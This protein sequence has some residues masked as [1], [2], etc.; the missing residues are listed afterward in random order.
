MKLRTHNKDNYTNTKIQDKITLPVKIGEWGA[1]M[2]LCL[3]LLAGLTSGAQAQKRVSNVGSDLNNINTSLECATAFTTGSNSSGYP[4]SSVDIRLK[5]VS[6][7]TTVVRIREGADTDPGDIVVTLTNPA[8]FKANALNKFTAPSGTVLNPNTTYFLVVNDGRASSAS[9]NVQLAYTYS[10]SQTGETDWSIGNSSRFRGSGSWFTTSL[11]EIPIFCINPPTVNLSVSG[12]GAI[13]EGGTPLTLT[14]TR[15]ETNTSGSNLS[16]PIQIKTTGTTAQAVD[17]MVASSISIPNNSATGTTLFGVTDDSDV[18]PTETVVIELGTL[19]SGS[20]AGSN[21]EVTLTIN[22][23]DAEPPAQPTGLMAMAG[24]VE[25]FLTWTNPESRDITN[26]QYRQKTGSNAYGNWITI[27]GS[28]AVTTTYIVTGLTN[29]TVY[30]FQVRAQVGAVG[31]AASEEVSATP[32][33]YAQTML[34][35]N[36]NTETGSLTSYNEYGTPFTTGSNGSG[37]TISSVDIFL[38]NVSGRST[39]VAIRENKN[40]NPSKLVAKLIKPNSF[41]ANTLNTFTA[42]D[43]T[44]LKPNTTYYLMVNDG[45]RRTRGVN[46]SNVQIS[47]TR[48]GSRTSVAGWSIA[49]FSR[50]RFGSAWNQALNE[51]M[52]FAIN[53]TINRPTVYLSVSGGGAINEGENPLTL[54]ATRSETNTSGLDLVIPIQVKSDGTT[55]Q[56]TDYT[57]AASISIPN[58]SAVG[59]TPFAVIDD[60]LV[61]GTETVVIELGTLPEGTIAGS[62]N[63]VTLTIND[64]PEISI[65]SR[66][67]VAVTEGTD[68]VFTVT[69]TPAPT[70]SLIVNLT[71]AEAAGSNFVTSG[72]KGSNKTVT[73]P[74]SG[75]VTYAVATVD[76]GI[77]EPNGSVM[78]TITDGSDYTVG[79]TS[80]ARVTIND[81]DTVPVINPVATASVAEGTNEVLT[82]TATDDDAGTTLMYA[83]SGGT[84]GALFSIDASSGVLTFITA[85]DFEMPSDQGRDNDYEVEVGVSDGTNST[86]QTIT[87]TVTDVNDNDPIITSDA[88]ASIVEGTTDVLTVTATDADAGAVIRYSVSG[89]ADG[90]L[91]AIE[92]TSGALTFINAPDFEG[93]SADGDDD[94]EVIVTASDG[95]N[96][97]MQTITVTVTDVNDNDPVITSDATATLAENT[98]DVLTVTATDADAGAVI[99]YSISGGADRSLFSIDANSGV[100]TFITAP[101]FEGASAD[102]DDDYEVIVT[103]SDGDNSVM[104][105]ITVTVTDVND[106]DPIITSDATASIVEGTT[107]VLT[108]TATDADEG[109][110]FTYSTSGG[111]DRNVFSINSTSGALVFRR[112][113]DFENRRDQD[114]DNDYEVE[115]GVSDGRNSV[116]Q[117]I[118]VTVT[119]DP[120]DDVLGF[121]ADEEEAVIFPNPSGDYLEVRSIAEGTFQL[122][123]LSG[124]RLL[125]GTINTRI[126]ITSLPSGLYLVQL[127][128][129]RLLKF[130]RE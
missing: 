66:S 97:V 80:S 78:V 106:N 83:I 71:V 21:A 32:S 100:L 93:A 46:G 98:T 45:R 89:G 124:K 39:T 68:A 5:K 13:N 95:D 7:R 43:N 74:M 16:I 64:K 23:N 121:S 63:Q 49:S 103:V 128:D 25:V 4:I 94:Y 123:S 14:A 18:E 114:R 120:A 104:Q 99:R 26:W 118:T 48:S 79:S 105:T 31:S 24:N 122:L 50:F 96:S 28:T 125:G 56:A 55:A 82:V 19:P 91:F 73:I 1:K 116:T 54:T 61:E 12:G 90:A 72:N 57:V 101:D 86:T 6:R 117:T 62:N 2:A 36:T 59:T 11:T 33:L 20:I 113:P 65:V 76:D 110:T 107:D 3:C 38:L 42:P 47:R 127:P 15:S 17:Y 41:K 22:D 109:T 67:N 52:R 115:V 29:G 108:V 87:I 53:G 51:R 35:S 129:G 44:V 102:G 9:S 85:P 70:S 30:T 84:D 58:N 88:T 10:D 81:D 8:T 40:S 112:T 34:L 119:N 77:D 111:A 69:A 75:S 130:V 92:E 60:N 126:D 37:Y 27:P